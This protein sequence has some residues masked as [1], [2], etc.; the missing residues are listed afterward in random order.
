MKTI[1]LSLGLVSNIRF[2]TAKE[3][4]LYWKEKKINKKP[5]DF[6]T[7]MPGGELTSSC[8]RHSSE[9]F[10][11]T[12]DIEQPPGVNSITASV[13]WNKVHIRTSPEVIFTLSICEVYTKCTYG[14]PSFKLPSDNGCNNCLPQFPALTFRAWTRKYINLYIYVCV[15]VYICIH[16]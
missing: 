11:H 8:C 15:C 3:Q 13:A 6:L 2:T 5:T 12:A 10:D 9:K 4:K 1:I 16:L 14:K 7:R